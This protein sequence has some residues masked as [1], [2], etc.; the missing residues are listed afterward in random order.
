MD[1]G[2]GTA[3]A[4]HTAGRCLGYTSGPETLLPSDSIGGI[5]LNEVSGGDSHRRRN[6]LTGDWVLVSPGRADRPWSGEDD[7]SSTETGDEHRQDCPLCPDTLRS[8]GERNPRYHGPYVFKNDFSALT[9]STPPTANDVQQETRDDLPDFL[10]ASPA[11]GEC[12]VICFDHRH[13]RTLA[14]LTPAELEKLLELQQREYQELAS[15]YPCV[16]LFENKGEM[17]GCSQPHPHG[18]IWAHDH[19]SSMILREEANQEAYFQTHGSALLAD[20]QAWESSA[21]ERVVFEN[22]AWLVVVPYWAAWPFETLVVTKQAI[23][24]LGELTAH[25]RETL[26]ETLA[27]VTRCYDALFGCPFPYSMG[28]HSAPTNKV[29][30]HWRLHAHFFPPLLRSATVKKHMV[31]YEMLGESQRDLTPES[32]AARLRPLADHVLQQLSGVR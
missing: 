15:R 10:R 24:H 28:W 18:Q 21:G 19:L 3:E 30:P 16:T 8:N 5:L 4:Q 14:D 2:Y 12:R 25:H 17:M 6:A 20:Y 1:E 27:V 7:L 11:R 29:A 26:A 13:N 32:A 22:S 31:G 23:T 9:Q